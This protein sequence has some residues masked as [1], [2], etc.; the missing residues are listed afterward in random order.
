MTKKLSILSIVVVLL[1][2]LCLVGCGDSSGADSKSDNDS[3][4]LEDYSKEIVGTW[5]ETEMI[6]HEKLNSVSEDRAIVLVFNSDGSFQEKE[7]GV[8]GKISLKG[9]YSIK[10]DKIYIEDQYG[11]SSINIKSLSKNELVLNNEGIQTFKKQ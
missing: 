7:N 3:V 10:E 1:F 8:N 5:I 11:K 6:K 2:S 9:T 4:A